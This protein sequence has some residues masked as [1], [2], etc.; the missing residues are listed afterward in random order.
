MY[1]LMLFVLTI[2]L[3]A[4]T[5]LAGGWGGC[6]GGGWSG[7]GRMAGG[8][9]A[10][11]GGGGTYVRNYGGCGGGYEVFDSCDSSLDYTQTRT[12]TSFNGCGC[13]LPTNYYDQKTPLQAS[14]MP[15]EPQKATQPTPAP[16]KALPAA[17]SGPGPFE[18]TSYRPV[19]MVSPTRTADARIVLELPASARVW[20]N[21][22]PTRSQGVHREFVSRDLLVGRQ[23]TYRVVIQVGDQVSQHEIRLTAG[24]TRVIR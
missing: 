24:Q 10:G 20:V 1:R 2:L 3:T 9:M 11:C 8:Y 7:G 6:G 23:Y 5:A 18:S 15:S 21:D 16:T 22:L 14:P 4:S 17:P 19:S 12:V 13:E